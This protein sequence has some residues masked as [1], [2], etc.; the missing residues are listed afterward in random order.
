MAS[1]PNAVKA[2]TTKN[3]GDTIQPADVND[4]QDEVAAIETGLLNGTAPL[5]SSH[6][7]LASLSVTG[8]STLASLSVAGASSLA[9]LHVTGASTFA[10]AVTFTGAVSGFFTPSVYCQ[11]SH[12][13]LQE[14]ANNTWTG[15]NFDTEDAI[16]GAGVH[17][18]AANSSRINLTSSGLFWMAAQVS[19]NPNTAAVLGARLV[20]NDTVYLSAAALQVGLNSAGVG[21]AMGVQALYYATS[22]GD[23]VGVQGFHN[24]GSTLSVSNST[25]KY[26]MNHFSLMKLL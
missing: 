2:F 24:N 20:A 22:T 15:L 1:Y 11:L 6:S 19:F 5:N 9:S 13:V 12:H 8:G 26:L 3:A 21:G 7:T 16:K 25:S 18:T 17:S 10:G 14:L 4:V 23:F